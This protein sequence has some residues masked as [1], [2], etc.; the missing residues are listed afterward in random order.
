M[1]NYPHYT[2]EIKTKLVD[3]TLDVRLI[4]N[5]LRLEGKLVV[6]ENVMDKA[7][8]LKDISDRSSYELVNVVCGTIAANHLILPKKKP[9]EVHND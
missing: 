2:T 8:S 6:I 7:F 9:G 1:S 3:D 4:T 5:I